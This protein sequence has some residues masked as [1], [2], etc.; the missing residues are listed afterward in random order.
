MFYF[1]QF[2]RLSEILFSAAEEEGLVDPHKI[3]AILKAANIK[4][5][6]ALTNAVTGSYIIFIISCHSLFVTA[7]L[8]RTF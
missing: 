5:Y 7:V 1:D 2:Q 6:N 3:E 8:V 4:T